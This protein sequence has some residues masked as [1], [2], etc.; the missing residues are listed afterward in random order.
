MKTTI[1]IVSL[2]LSSTLFSQIIWVPDDYE[3]IQEAII[4][5]SDGDTVIVEVGTD[6]E[7]INYW[8]KAITVA[9]RFILDG[10]ED[11][12]LNTIIE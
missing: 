10:D 3:T 6:Y 7:N 9:S 1:I 4:A 8:G 5:S 12:I 2:F 11:H